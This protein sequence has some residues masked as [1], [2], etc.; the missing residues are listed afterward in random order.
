MKTIGGF[1]EY[2]QFHHDL[3]WHRYIEKNSDHRQHIIWLFPKNYLDLRLSFSIAK[4]ITTNHGSTNDM[5]GICE[6]P[7]SDVF[8]CSRVL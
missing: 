5:C 2:I 8:S 1:A 4:L 6:R 7:F 3:S